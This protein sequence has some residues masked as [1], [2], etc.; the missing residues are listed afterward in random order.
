MQ[1]LGFF[2]D[3]LNFSNPQTFDNLFEIWGPDY[4]T[5]LVGRFITCTNWL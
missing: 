2:E 4:F 5:I 1:H 3:W